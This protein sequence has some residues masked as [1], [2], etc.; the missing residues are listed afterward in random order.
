MTYFRNKI[1]LSAARCYLAVVSI[2]YSA[3]KVTAVIYLAIVLPIA[4]VKYAIDGWASDLVASLLALWWPCQHFTGAGKQQIFSFMPECFLAHLRWALN[5]SLTCGGMFSYQAV[6]KIHM[7]KIQNQIYHW[8]LWFSLGLMQQ[9]G[10]W[11]FAL[12]KE[13][14][15]DRSFNTKWK[16][17]SVANIE[18]TL[19][20]ALHYRSP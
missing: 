2:V 14:L 15:L 6:K 9:P 1:L 11:S 7:G 13:T 4:A 10:K 8:D 12:V 5:S 3:V 16:H 20:F 19:N 17:T 18:S